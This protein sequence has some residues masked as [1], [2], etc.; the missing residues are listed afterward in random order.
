MGKEFNKGI[1]VGMLV[2]FFLVGNVLNA[3]KLG[4]WE[5]IATIGIA[6]YLFIAK[7]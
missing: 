7:G 3:I 5:T 6:A 2:S 1:A 4:S